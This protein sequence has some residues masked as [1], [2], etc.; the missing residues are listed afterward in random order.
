MAW[1]GP[2]PDWSLD[3]LRPAAVNAAPPVCYDSARRREDFTFTSSVPRDPSGF[4]FMFE[5]RVRRDWSRGFR[6]LGRSP[7][8]YPHGP[9][10]PTPMF[11]LPIRS[12][13]WWK[14]VWTGS[15]SVTIF[16]H[17]LRD[18]QGQMGELLGRIA[19]HDVV[20]SHCLPHELVCCGDVADL[21]RSPPRPYPCL[22]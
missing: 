14:L 7:R 15:M 11:L 9:P 22:S 17:E 16:V 8:C 20:G 19:P 4:S 21:R 3:A 13:T 6:C 18:S 10:P 1:L 5:Q 12:V 2:R